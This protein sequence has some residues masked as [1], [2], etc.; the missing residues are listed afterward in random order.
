[1]EYQI[2]IP[3]RANSKRL[4][5][6]N[7]KLLGSKPLIE[8]SI[9]TALLIFPKERVWVNTDDDQIIKYAK[10]KGL[11]TMLRP[12]NLALDSTTTVDVLKHQIDYFKNRNIKCNAIILLQPTNPFREDDLLEHAIL[13]FQE[14]GR[15]SLATFS[16]NEKK[17]GKIEG[18]FFRP[19]NYTPGQRSQDLENS[20]FENGL[21]YITKVESILNN[22]IITD[23]VFP[24]I[25][26]NI[27][28]TVDIDYLEDFI[29]A[30][31]LLKIK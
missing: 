22:K 8:Y 31:A 19:T 26:D 12:D 29:F 13:K 25:C 2:I 11:N 15:C 18:D 10:L 1:L 28:A 7:M 14:S 9:D 23:D 30:E 21:L 27:E 24:I 5:G 4:P 6:K 3:A 20:Y 17:L 16:K